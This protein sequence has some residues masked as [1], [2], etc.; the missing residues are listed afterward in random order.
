[1]Q[2][3]WSYVNNFK[4]K[5]K[6]LG[7]L[8]G[9]ITLVTANVVALFSSIPHEDGLE[10]LRERLV[11]SEVLKLPVN[12]IATMA[13]FVLK[14]NILEING[15]VKQQVSGTAI[16]TKFAPRYAC[17]Y[18]GETKTKFLKTQELQPLVWFGYI[19]DILLYG[20]T[21]RMN[22]TNF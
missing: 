17:I 21:V 15:K 18:M 9:N 10:T 20:I 2:N 12:N 19:G 4:N 16:V 3:D 14:N 6:K 7:K 11:Q 22:F 8:S 1:M 13:E 5:I